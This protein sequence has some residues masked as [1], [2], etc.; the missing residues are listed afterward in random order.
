MS[1]KSDFEVTKNDKKQT[2]NQHFL[3]RKLVALFYLEIHFKSV[4]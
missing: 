2:A 1:L 4:M 3:S